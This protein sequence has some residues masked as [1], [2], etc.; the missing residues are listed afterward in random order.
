MIGTRPVALQEHLVGAERPLSL[1]ST[2]H[3]WLLQPQVLLDTLLYP[4]V[5]WIPVSNA[6]A[7]A[8]CEHVDTHM[9]IAKARQVFWLQQSG[10]T[11]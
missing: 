1:C 9:V 10:T 8:A 5:P 3:K 7:A 6:L 2:T 11:L 4:C